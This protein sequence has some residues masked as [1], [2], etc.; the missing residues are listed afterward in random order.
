MPQMAFIHHRLADKGA[1]FSTSYV[2][3]FDIKLKED[4]QR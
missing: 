4:S 2:N 1:G 3:R